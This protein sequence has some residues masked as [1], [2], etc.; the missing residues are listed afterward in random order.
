MVVFT[1]ENRGGSALITLNVQ[2]T[3]NVDAHHGV[4]LRRPKTW[5][6]LIASCIDYHMKPLESRNFLTR[7]LHA[8]S[9]GQS[10]QLFQMFTYMMMAA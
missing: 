1:R 10:Y 9:G 2:N 7:N 5:Q 6:P 3:Y 8:E 4:L